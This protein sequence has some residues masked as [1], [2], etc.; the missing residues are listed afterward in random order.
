MISTLEKS[1]AVYASSPSEKAQWIGHMEKCVEDLLHSGLPP[2]M[3]SAGKDPLGCN[4]CYESRYG[5]KRPEKPPR[6]NQGLQR[7]NKIQDTSIDEEVVTEPVA[8]KKE[9]PPRPPPPKL[10]PDGD[11]P[12]ESDAPMPGRVFE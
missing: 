5:D 2:A 6:V 7:Q 4:P 11:K 10:F 9:A 12:Y 1:F 8:E 3:K